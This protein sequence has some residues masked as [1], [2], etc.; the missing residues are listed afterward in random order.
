MKCYC[1]FRIEQTGVIMPILKKIS[2]LSLSLVPISILYA[3]NTSIAFFASNN[4]GILK[5]QQAY[6]RLLSEPQEQLRKEITH[7]LQQHHL[8]QNEVEEGIGMY[9][10]AA[11][12]QQTADNSEVFITSP[13]QEISKQRAFDIAAAI[14]RQLQQES[15]AVFVPTTQQASGDVILHLTSH[16]YHLPE[17]MQLIQN[18]LPPEYAKAYSIHFANKDG[19]YEHATIASIEWLGS[20]IDP[21]LIEQ[22]FPKDRTTVKHG[23]TYLVYQDGKKEEI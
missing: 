11:D 8:E 9:Q 3:A 21:S 14:A 10:M 2:L 16:P 1:L 18:K 17:I 13:Y 19:G 12:G 7:I 4:T 23:R 5:P 20:Q 22:A 6:E 15:V